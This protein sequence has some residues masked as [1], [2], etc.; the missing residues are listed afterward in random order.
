MHRAKRIAPR[1]CGWKHGDSGY[2]VGKNFCQRNKSRT[3]YEPTIPLTPT[4]LLMEGHFTQNP[5]QVQ[6]LLRGKKVREIADAMQVSQA[7]AAFVRSGRRRHR[8][9]P[10]R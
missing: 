3:Q 10:S 8:N 4:G 5:P 7:Y 1:E 2:S 9:P 6:P